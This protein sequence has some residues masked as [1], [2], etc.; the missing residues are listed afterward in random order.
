M[1]VTPTASEGTLFAHLYDV[2]RLGVAKL[3]THTPY[4]FADRQAGRPFA[5]DVT[6]QSTA[7]G[8]PAGHRLALAVDTVDAVH[9]ENDPAS[10][11]VTFSSRRPTG[12]SG[13]SATTSAGRG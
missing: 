12:R 10:A 6:F 3:I 1:T 11:K 13:A 7:Y 9:K 8:V 5:A 4:G 2:D